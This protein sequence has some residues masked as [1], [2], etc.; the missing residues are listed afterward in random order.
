VFVGVGV[1]VG[2]SVG[3]AVGVDVGVAVDDGVRVGVDVDVAVGVGGGR[4]IRIEVRAISITLRRATI[5]MVPVASAM[6][7]G[8]CL[9]TGDLDVWLTAAGVY[10][11]IGI[12][13]RMARCELRVGRIA[14]SELGIRVCGLRGRRA[15]N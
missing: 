2:V 4:G 9:L 1:L 7:G 14:S 13:A 12:L 15:A 6:R 8:M 10:R 11:N 3:V 5:R